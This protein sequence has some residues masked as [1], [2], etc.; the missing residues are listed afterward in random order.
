MNCLNIFSSTVIFF[1]FTLILMMIVF[2][3]VLCKKNV[4]LHTW[5][6]LCFFVWS[7]GYLS[8]FIFCMQPPFDPIGPP[9]YYDGPPLPE[10]PSSRSRSEKRQSADVRMKPFFCFSGLVGI[11]IWWLP[12]QHYVILCILAWIVIYVAAFLVY[13]VNVNV[14]SVNFGLLVWY[15]ACNIWFVR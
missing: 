3:F 1:F 6:S 8:I 10:Y 2:Y 15:K 12:Y 14:Y 9:R 11:H 13:S 5:G 7:L 4:N